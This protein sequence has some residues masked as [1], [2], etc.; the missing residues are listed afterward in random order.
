MDADGIRKP[1]DTELAQNLQI[2]VRC[3]RI[4]RLACS[5]AEFFFPVILRTMI[6]E[7][8]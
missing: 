6:S 4:L 1:E 7:H 5:R 3:D 8:L 2:E